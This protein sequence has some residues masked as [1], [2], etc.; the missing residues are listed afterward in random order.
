[1]TWINTRNSPWHIQVNRMHLVLFPLP[2]SLRPRCKCRC[3]P[4]TRSKYTFTNTTIP[5]PKHTHTSVCQI[6]VPKYQ[7]HPPHLLGR[8]RD[9][10]ADVPPWLDLPHVRLSN[11][12]ALSPLLRF[13]RLFKTDSLQLPSLVA[14]QNF[15]TKVFGLRS[16]RVKVR[17]LFHQQS[18]EQ[19]PFLERWES[20]DGAGTLQSAPADSKLSPD[21]LVILH[22][23][24]LVLL[25]L[26]LL[27]LTLF[28]TL[29]RARHKCFTKFMEE[30]FWKIWSSSW[31]WTIVPLNYQASAKAHTLMT[32]MG[33]N[34]IH[35]SKMSEIKMIWSI[36][37]HCII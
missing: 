23:L 8:G 26:L 28:E 7:I 27:L 21:L 18:A 25:L 29:T 34:I 2:S 4:H 24:L 32:R 9:A 31:L 5:R 35:E 36:C 19:R 20:R 30:L 6:H 15:A 33:R 17:E 22:L 13:L 10:T 11:V 12:S 37:Q 3:S 14:E 1:M 16:E